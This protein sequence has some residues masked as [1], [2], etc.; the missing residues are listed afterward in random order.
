MNIKLLSLDPSFRNWG[1]VIA[2]YDAV[3]HLLHIHSGGVLSSKPDKSNTK[4]NTK[5]LKVSCYLYKHLVQ[6]TKDIDIVIAEVPHGSQ[7][8]RA[9]VSYG[10]CIGLLG[11]IQQPLIQISAMDVKRLVGS[12]TASKDDV[13]NWVKQHYQLDWLPKAKSKSEHICDAIAALHIGI[14]SKQF[15]E[16]YETIT[17]N[18]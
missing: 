1:F 18:S 17:N 12:N 8:S 9:M 15:K 5:D 13:I 7:S 2:E 10:V 14:Q 16:Y 3:N 4:Q 6:L 11:C